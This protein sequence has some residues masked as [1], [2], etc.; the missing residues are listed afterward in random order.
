MALHDPLT[1]LPNRA[2]LL[3]RIEQTLHGRRRPAEPTAVVYCD[4]DGFKR[5]NDTLAHAA[6][7][8]ALLRTAEALRGV[9]RRGDT[10]ARI[11][12]DEFVVLC[13]GLGTDAEAR[14][15]VGRI[16]AGLAT[17][18][19]ALRASCGYALSLPDDSADTL[20]RRVD[21]AMYRVK[22]ARRSPAVEQ[23]RPVD[24]DP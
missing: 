22:A 2:L 3:V 16:D 1:G 11:G 24:A 9:V 12:G 10:V 20:L 6:G 18:G 17:H 13:P 23:R 7:D 8:A 15:L 21:E 19:G 4:L 14:A 5:V